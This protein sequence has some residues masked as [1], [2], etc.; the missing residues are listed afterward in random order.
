MKET[1]EITLGCIMGLFLVILALLAETLIVWLVGIGFVQAF[2][3]DHVVTF[4]QA[5]MVSVIIDIIL[6][7]F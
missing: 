4:A 1:T 7:I 6:A 3:I 5:F 2:H